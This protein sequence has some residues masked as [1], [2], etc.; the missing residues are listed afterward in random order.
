M[1]ATQLGMLLDGDV[2]GLAPA[3]DVADG[4]DE[5]LAHGLSR[6]GEP[7]RAAL[8]A[9]AAAV[10][11]SPLA[12]PV[13]EAVAKLAAGT[14]A[15]AYLAALAGA[16]AALFGA[17]H[18]AL[19][20]RFDAALGRRRDEW[21]GA[22]ADAAGLPLAAARSWLTELAVTG[23][24][25]VDED[26]VA[27]SASVVAALLAE[28]RTRRLAVLLDGFGAEL[29]A[30]APIATMELLPLRR[31]GDLWSRAVLLAQDA[32]PGPVEPTP[33][34]GRLLPLGVDVHEHATAV[35]LQVHG[36]LESADG[37]RLVRTSLVVAKVDTIVGPAVWTLFDAPVL[38]GALAEHRALELTDMPS[39]PGGDLHWCEEA[40]RPGEPA[41]PF[42]TARL[43]LPTATAA[44]PSPLDRHP[45]RIAEPV[46]VEDYQVVDGA[47]VLGE[48]R[49]RFDLDRLP[50]CGPLTP[51]LVAGS[52][53]CIGL[54]RWDAG[55]WLLQPLAVRA[56]V[57][58]RPA[59][60]GTGD[61]ALGPTD[62]KVA[63]AEAKNDAVSVL[64]ERAGR[65]L[66]S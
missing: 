34:S 65:L 27:A 46:L 8:T 52:T 59:Q 22:G 54:L 61:W 43:T 4:L 31:W 39:L 49:L 35:Q 9:L 18:D 51:A 37:V 19:L 41:D 16:R 25:G 14:V 13:G 53:G 62:A 47:A 60:T 26:L 45:A 55:E 57:K 1:L 32:W 50:G 11:T 48:H 20:A 40:A 12:V 29:R 30:C 64:R 38:L 63:K 66:R 28:P 24:R 2:A 5:V 33:V 58:R 36:V 17:A 15:D 56:T 7:E 23:W 42:T 21:V 10:G 44:A 6:L 3:L